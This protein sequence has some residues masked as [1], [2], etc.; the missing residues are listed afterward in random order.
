MNEHLKQRGFQAF[1]EVH[2]VIDFHDGII[3]ISKGH[4]LGDLQT[5]TVV[6]G[7]SENIEGQIRELDTICDLSQSGKNILLCGLKAGFPKIGNQID[8][9]WGGR[10]NNGDLM[11]ILAYLL[12]LNQGWQNAQ[13]RILSVVSNESAKYK[14]SYPN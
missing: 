7:W 5:N 6:F 11:L 12:K 13:I 10:E 2:P 3:E 14:L 4:G 9:W 8:I 1:C